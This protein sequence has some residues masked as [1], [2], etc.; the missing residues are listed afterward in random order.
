MEK[1]DRNHNMKR[2]ECLVKDFALV[3][4]A[5]RNMEIAV[6]DEIYILETS[7]LQ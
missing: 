7:F 1:A 6:Y 4:C 2:F 5:M 3:V